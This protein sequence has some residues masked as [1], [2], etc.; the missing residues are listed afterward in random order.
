MIQ[1]IDVSKIWQVKK[2]SANKNPKIVKT[3][4]QVQN[5]SDKFEYFIL[6][7]LKGLK[8]IGQRDYLVPYCGRVLAY[9]K[10][11]TGTWYIS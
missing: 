3:S 11:S 7:R 9:I 6:K 8:M 10:R 5:G 1:T 4:C 2:L